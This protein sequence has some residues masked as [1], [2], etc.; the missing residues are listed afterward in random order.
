M[1]HFREEQENEHSGGR[2]EGEGRSDGVRRGQA[3]QV[4]LHR[5]L[6]SLWLLL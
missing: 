4:R 5:P 1:A 3:D 6:Y 2:G